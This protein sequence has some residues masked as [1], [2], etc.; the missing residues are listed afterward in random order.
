MGN[1]S[2]IKLLLDRDD[3][4]ADAQDCRGRTPLSFAAQ[5]R[6]KAVLKLLLDRSDVVINSSDNLGRTPLDYATSYR[7]WESDAAVQFLQ[8][9]L[10]LLCAENATEV[11]QRDLEMVWSPDRR[12]SELY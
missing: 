4:A 3:V 11:D 12:Y 7:Q 2:V 8:D 5:H 6:H 1:H 9:R 10:R